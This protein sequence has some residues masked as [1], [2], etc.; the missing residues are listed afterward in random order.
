MSTIFQTKEQPIPDTPLL[1]FDCVMTDGSAEHWGTQAVTVGA[2]QYAGRVAKHN[3]FE[4]QTA[5]GQGVDSIPKL[6]IDLAN[7]DSYFSELE[8]NKGFK[9]AKLTARFVFFD[10]KKRVP[11]TETAV[12]FQGIANAPELITE[13]AFRLSAMNRLSMQRVY[14]P[15]VRVQRRCAWDF[16]A[17]AEQRTEA[18]DGGVKGRFSRYYACGYSPDIAGGRGNLNGQNPFTTCSYTRSD[19]EGRGMFHADSQQRATARFSGIEFVPSTIV[20]RSAG[21]KS[22]QLSAVSLNEGRYNGFVPLVYGTAWYAPSIVFARNDGN[23]TRMEVLLGAGEMHAVYKVLVNGIDIPTGR[24]GQN[25]TGTGWFNVVTYGTRNGGFNLDFTNSGGAPLGDPYGSMAYLSVVVPNRINDGQTL[26]SIQV[27]VDGVKLL[28]YAADGT[29]TDGQFSNNPCWIILDVLLR[30]G[31]TANEMDLASFAAAAAYC[32]EQIPAKD[33]NGNATMIPRFQCNVVLQA[34]RSVGDVLRGIRNSSRLYLSFGFNGLLQLKVENTLA[35]QQPAKPLNSNASASLNGGW[36]AY[37]FGDGANGTTGILRNADGSSTVR[38]SSSG[39]V[40]C[41]NRFSVEF[42]DSFNEYQQDSFTLVNSDDVILTGQEINSN[43]NALGIANYDQAA[44]ILQFNLEKSIQGNV[45]VEFQTSVKALGLAPGDIITLTYLKEGFERQ[46]F[47]IAKIV[48]TTNYRTATITA[49][50]HDDSWYSDD[51]GLGSATGARRLPGYGIG[52]PRP[53]SGTHL[54]ADGELEFGVTESSSQSQDGTTTLVAT[55]TYIAPAAIPESAPAIPILSLAASISTTGGTLSGAQTLYY[56]LS[57]VDAQGNESPLSFVVPAAIPPT[58]STNTVTLQELSFP[59][60]AGS[61]HVYRGPNPTQ[62]Y[63]IASAVTIAP[64][65]TDIGLPDQAILPPDPNFD[66]ANFYWRLELQGEA[67]ATIQSSTTVGNSV[68]AMIADEYAGMT[69]RIVRGT[70]ASQ[71]RII[72]SNDA[73]SLTVKT[74]WDIQLDPTSVFVVAESGYQSGATGKTNVLQFP[75]PN[76]PNAIIQISGRSANSNDVECP[77]EVS[78]LTRWK[79]GGA[80]L[81]TTDADVP[82]IPTFGL[83]LSAVKGGTVTLGA[84]GFTD[85]TNTS[86]ISAGTYTFFYYDETQGPPVVSLMGVVGSDDSS[87]QLSAAYTGEADSFIQLEGEILQVSQVSSDGLQ[88]QVARG[89][90]GSTAASHS[91]ATLVYALASKITIVPF[92]RNFFGTPAS[93]DWSYSLALPNVRIAA[94]QLYVNNSQ[95]SSPAATGN[96]MTTSDFGLRTLSGG[97]Y[98]FQ[99]AGFLAIQTGAAPDISIEAERVIRDVFATVNAAASQTTGIAANVNLDGNPLCTLSFA[100]GATT[101]N[102]VSGLTLPPLKSGARLS[103]DVVSVGETFP[104]SDLTV[105]IR[106]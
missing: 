84:I 23:L 67:N 21:S 53:V 94:A 61:F 1:L 103:L 87:I 75:I 49:H 13:T 12:L 104:G 10:L 50:I 85:L 29:A 58:T 97:Q 91:A 99:I 81:K 73:T 37:E 83:S 46:P 60:S 93:G 77:Y 19:C 65:F 3:L 54:D 28:K 62:L 24:S 56:A 16:P 45:T 79:I 82:A 41:P 71:E 2:V 47:R 52:L 34:R 98:A 70:G 22:T 4:M 66:H 69:V 33:L 5:S 63:R 20:V 92:I 57:S 68:L 42:Q 76:R 39:A 25:M 59:S 48:P 8:R 9:G 55:V 86:S 102:V 72:V 43:L 80:G 36:P 44:R 27:L 38:L 6:S 51:N 100:P 106:V 31:W 95:G 32:D 64:V 18:V 35:L 88:L 15:P 105:M 96:F 89:S 26:P 7:A 11:G 78:P 30:N 40:D 90:L 14:L 74:P 101:S 17:T